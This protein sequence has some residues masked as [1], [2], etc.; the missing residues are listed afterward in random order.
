MR[1]NL[2]I[3]LVELCNLSGSLLALFI[4]VN[5]HSLHPIFPRIQILHDHQQR[6]NNVVYCC[7]KWS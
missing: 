4:K 7:G 2:E 5:P 1:L 3:Y 6:N